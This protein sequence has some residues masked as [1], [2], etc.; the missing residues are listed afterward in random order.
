[1][2]IVLSTGTSRDGGVMVQ[3][4]MVCRCLP[5]AE[6]GRSLLAY[7]PEHRWYFGLG[8]MVA[9]NGVSGE[10]GLSSEVRK[11]TVACRFR[12]HNERERPVFL[13][14]TVSEPHVLSLSGSCAPELLS[15]WLLASGF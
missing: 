5:E 4:R 14:D 13:L 15:S 9:F 8:A 10:W 7:V 1:M 6:I 11:S 2:L 3:P 12:V